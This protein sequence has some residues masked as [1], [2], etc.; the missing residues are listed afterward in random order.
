MIVRIDKCFERDVRKIQD[1]S[2]KNKLAYTI[3]KI[4]NAQNVSEIT[5]LKKIKG[6]NFYYRIRL[7][8]YR[9]GIIIRKKEVLLVRF[10]HR[11]DIYKYFP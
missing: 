3:N 6:T 2:A 11:K 1:Q 9:L 5:G 7:G 8:E 4:Q 10:L